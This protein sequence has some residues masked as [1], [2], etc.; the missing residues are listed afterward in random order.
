MA[1]GTKRRLRG[2]S[3]PLRALYSLRLEEPA[4]TRLRGLLEQGAA[5]AATG[6]GGPLLR[7]AE[8]GGLTLVLGDAEEDRI[9]LHATELVR[10]ESEVYVEEG[11]TSLRRYGSLVSRLRPKGR[12]TLEKLHDFDASLRMDQAAKR[13]RIARDL[14]EYVPAA[15]GDPRP[16]RAAGDPP[17][18]AA[19]AP[20]RPRGSSPGSALKSVAV[21]L[22][23]SPTGALL[24]ASPEE[25]AQS[26]LRNCDLQLGVASLRVLPL[27]SAAQPSV[28]ALLSQ[29]R[30]ASLALA[31]DGEEFRIAGGTA[32]VEVR[33]CSEEEAR[34]ATMLGVWSPRSAPLR[35]TWRRVCE[36]LAP[37]GGF[38]AHYEAC[39]ALCAAGEGARRRPRDLREA[40]R[41]GFEVSLRC[42][43]SRGA[44]PAG[45]LAEHCLAQAERVAAACGAVAGEELNAQA[46][47]LIFPAGAD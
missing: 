47:A 45:E 4:A 19:A 25:L 33:P 36:H 12:L 11:G 2:A 18:G 7:V 5:P 13:Q 46:A 27:P 9:A 41:G 37:A 15:A 40:A 17:R 22:M 29:R 24:A 8:D 32:A 38:L 43:L 31:R 6:R 3:G 1:P 20:R 44:A 28:V 35:E 26:V 10:G 14:D 16:P 23:A 42:R 34:A 30:V 21:K 39:A